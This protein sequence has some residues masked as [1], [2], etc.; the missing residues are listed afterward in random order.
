MCIR[1][2]CTVPETAAVESSKQITLRS[3]GTRMLYCSKAVTRA[4]AQIS[5]APVSYTHLDVYKRQEKGPL[6]CVQAEEIRGE[7]V[8]SEAQLT[9][10]FPKK[11]HAEMELKA[12]LDGKVISLK[13]V[14]DGVFS[15][16]IMGDGLATVSYTHLHILRQ[17]YGGMFYLYLLY[18]TGYSLWG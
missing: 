17:L 4:A 18:D 15:E 5:L 9:E 11:A 7:D 10:K 6:N 13:E 8:D 16:G 3:S 2:S 1:D 14:G 12:F